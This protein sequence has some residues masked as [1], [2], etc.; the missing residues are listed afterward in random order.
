MTPLSYIQGKKREKKRKRKKKMLNNKKKYKIFEWKSNNHQSE[1]GDD[2]PIA[3]GEQVK[4]MQ[5]VQ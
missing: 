3:D 4:A 2:L 5:T 1:V